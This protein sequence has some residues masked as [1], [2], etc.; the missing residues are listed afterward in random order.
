MSPGA[1]I[2]RCREVLLAAAAEDALLGQA[3]DGDVDGWLRERA[4]AASARAAAY[5][6]TGAD[7]DAG[8]GAGEGEDEGEDEDED[9][10][11]DAGAAAGDEAMAGWSGRSWRIIRLEGH[12]GFEET[13]VVYSLSQPVTQ[14]G[15]CPLYI[16]TFHTDF[17]LVPR[18]QT[19]TALRV[20]RSHFD[21]AP[22]EA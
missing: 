1:F 13:G 8:S 10:G 21:V 9:A 11:S 12:W 20:L 17:I 19:K 14:E 4:A 2:E 3:G 6:S 15:I 5:A 7:A 18:P 22:E 16:S